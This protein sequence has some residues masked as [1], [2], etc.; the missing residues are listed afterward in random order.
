MN[1]HRWTEGGTIHKHSA[2]SSSYWMGREITN[3]HKYTLSAKSTTAITH[4]YHTCKLSKCPASKKS[5]RIPYL[6]TERRVPELIP[7]LGSEPA[8]DGIIN[9][10][11]G[12]HYFLTGLQLPPQPLRGLIPILLLG[13]QRHDGCEQFA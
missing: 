8:G 10:T 6:I 5:K 11:L 9:L 1:M 2:S 13:E 12:C 3:M 7:V 4:V